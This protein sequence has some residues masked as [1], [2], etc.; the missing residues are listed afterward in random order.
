[1]SE[2]YGT[3]SYWGWLL[4]DRCQLLREIGKYRLTTN[5]HQNLGRRGLIR[6]LY[7]VDFGRPSEMARERA[8]GAFWQL[9]RQKIAAAWGRR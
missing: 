9:T 3:N 2:G 5:D 7:V 6:Q 1:L 4:V 8:D